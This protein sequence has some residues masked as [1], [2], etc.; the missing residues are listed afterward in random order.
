MFGLRD[1]FRDAPFLENMESNTDEAP[2]DLTGQLP[3]VIRPSGRS[4]ADCRDVCF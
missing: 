3:D 4:R 1:K 2:P